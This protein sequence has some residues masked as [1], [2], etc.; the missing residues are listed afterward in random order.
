MTF[1]NNSV[2]VSYIICKTSLSSSRVQKCNT[3]APFLCILTNL[4]H[5]FNNYFSTFYEIYKIYILPYYNPM[6]SYFIIHDKWYPNMLYLIYIFP[7][8][9]PHIR[10]H[11]VC[12]LYLTA[13]AAL[14]RLT[15]V[16]PKYSYALTLDNF[17][18]WIFLLY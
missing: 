4:D 12:I 14:C 3:F 17:V 8:F 9:S 5:D 1:L 2:A 6:C 15:D 16:S 11:D 13:P 18:L 7:L 10:R